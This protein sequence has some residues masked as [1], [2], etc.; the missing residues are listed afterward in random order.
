MHDKK[1]NDFDVRDLKVK[2]LGLCGSQRRRGHTEFMVKESLRGAQKVKGVETELINLATKSVKPCL[3]QVCQDKKGWR[4]CR[5]TATS[6]KLDVS[7][8]PIDDDMRNE[9]TE[10]LLEAD[11]MIIGS[12]VYWGN[13]TGLLK[14]FMDRTSGLKVNKLW[15]R[16]KVGGALSVAAQ[17]HGGQ[18]F[19]ILAIENWFRIQGMIIVPDG[20]PTE[21]EIKEFGKFTYDSP[22]CN[23]SVVWARAHFCAGWADPDH[24]AIEKDALAIVNSRGL[25]RHVAEV[26]KWV[27]A[28]RPKIELKEYPVFPR[29]RGEIAERIR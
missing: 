17:R 27:K 9:L 11:G 2:I 6:G 8:C 16:D 24:G 7:K 28:G 21:E 3:V 10:K 15:L 29:T 18:E 5:I 13:V 23:S 22:S 20:A 25:G 26:S 1:R 12:P 4:H 19:T 14:T